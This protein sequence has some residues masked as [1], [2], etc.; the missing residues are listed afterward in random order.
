M[1]NQ[2]QNKYFKYQLL[3]VG[4]IYVQFKGVGDDFTPL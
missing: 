3:S 4:I 2:F 1:C